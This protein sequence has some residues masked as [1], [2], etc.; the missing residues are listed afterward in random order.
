MKR[1]ERPL[2][3]Y[4]TSEEVEAVL[5]GRMDPPGAASETA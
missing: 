3:G 5:N 2:L 1:F 4:L